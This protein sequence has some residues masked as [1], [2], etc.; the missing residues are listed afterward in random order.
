MRPYLFLTACVLSAVVLSSAQAGPRDDILTALGTQAKAES[1]GFTGFDAGR[2]KTLFNSQ[3]VGGKPET[4][5]CVSCH[6]VDPR[7]SG[8]TRAG[9][10]IEPMAVSVNPQRFTDPATV[11]KWFGR[12]CNSV[13]GRAC[14]AQE[15]G[16]FITYMSQQ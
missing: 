9:K 8:Q 5:A 2:G 11:D 6:D 15:K 4:P 7:K 10:A 14:T 12:N 13:L 16:D 3:H 1:P